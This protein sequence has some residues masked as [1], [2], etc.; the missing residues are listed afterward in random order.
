LLSARKTEG[1]MFVGPVIIRS[2]RSFIENTMIGFG[3]LPFIFAA[4][5]R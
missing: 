5:P 2:S 1:S 4:N 3:T